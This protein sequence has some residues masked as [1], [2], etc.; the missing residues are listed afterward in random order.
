MAL[1]V[2]NEGID[3]QRVYVLEGGLAA[4]DAAGYPMASGNQP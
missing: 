3:P 4:W 2:I 1:T